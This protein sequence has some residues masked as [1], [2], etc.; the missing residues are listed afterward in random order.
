MTTKQIE[1]ILE[2]AKTLNFNHAA[3]NLYVAQSTIT[4]QIKSAED[5]IGFKIFERSGKGATLTPAGFQFCMALRNINQELKDAIE[6]GQNFARQYREDISIGL[7]VRTMIHKLP[8]AM[9]EFARQYPDVSV[10]PKFGA[11]GRLAAFSSGSLDILFDREENV[12][13]VPDIR[14]HPFY[15]C[16]FYLI[17]KKDDPLAMQEVIHLEDLKDRTLMVGG[18]S[19]PALRAL[20]D[21]IVRTYGVKHFNSQNHD[22]TL[23]NVA[24]GKGV[25]IAPGFLNDFSGE[26][27]WTPVDCEEHMSCVLCTHAGDNRKSVATFLGI[28]LKLYQE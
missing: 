28:L 8:E 1:Y 3:E 7:S 14:I 15:D 27:A 16:H 11:E 13:R 12:R 9:I 25:C 26:F 19:P 6:Q 20:Q 21:R 17:A 23:T 4:Y 24:A 5:E 2:L 22:T 18:G 10:T